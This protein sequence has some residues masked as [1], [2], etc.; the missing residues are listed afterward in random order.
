MQIVGK[1]KR[2]VIGTCLKRLKNGR[3]K[4]KQVLSK[5]LRETDKYERSN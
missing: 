4:D 3:K 2:R 5:T 1:D